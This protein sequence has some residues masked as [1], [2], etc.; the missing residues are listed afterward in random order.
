MTWLDRI[1]TV[2]V[3]VTCTSEDRGLKG[4]CTRKVYW[5]KRCHF[6]LDQGVISE[7]SDDLLKKKSALLSNFWALKKALPKKNLALKKAL[8]DRNLALKYHYQMGN[9]LSNI[10]TGREFGSQISLL[11]ENSALPSCNDI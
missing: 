1:D 5:L 4:L 8:P 10:I 11:D 3:F 6:P 9:W 2:R 7:N